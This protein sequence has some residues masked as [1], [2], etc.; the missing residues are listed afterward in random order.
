M[1]KSLVII[2][3][4]ML[5]GSTAPVKGQIIYTEEDH[6]TNLRQTTDGTF[7]VMVPMQGADMDQWKIAP[8]GNG[9]LLLAGLGGAYL[10]SKKRKK[11][12]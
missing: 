6:G 7:G 3:L 4:A 8:L 12:E 1:K 10:L 5:I 2:I 11:E 9:M